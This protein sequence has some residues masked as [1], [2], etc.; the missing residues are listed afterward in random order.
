MFICVLQSLS[1]WPLGIARHLH[2]RAESG[3]G[4]LMASNFLIQSSTA[5]QSEGTHAFLFDRGHK[6]QANKGAPSVSA[7]RKRSISIK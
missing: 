7:L 6:I 3:K 4:K 1:L 2:G 5:H